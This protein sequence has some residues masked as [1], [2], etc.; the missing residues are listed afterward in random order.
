[1]RLR[2]ASIKEEQYQKCL[3][4]C[5]WGS[6]KV[7][8]KEWKIGDYLAFK[9]DS[10]FS[11]LVRIS[12]ETYSDDLLIWENGYYQYRIPF[13]II[14]RLEVGNRVQHEGEIKDLF[15]KHYGKQ[16]GWTILNK[17]II[18]EEIS[19]CILSKFGIKEDS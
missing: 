9:V 12:G 15:L 5:V 3:E 14:K 8:M 17:V 10:E 18:N 11:A 19:K 1:M 7:V 16:Y 6:D 13:E 4:F 2:I